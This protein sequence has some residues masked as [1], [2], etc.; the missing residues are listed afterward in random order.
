MPLLTACRAALATAL[1]LAGAL[2]LTSAPAQAAGLAD[3]YVALGDSFTAGPLIPGQYGSP[4]FC[5][6]SRQNYPNLVASALGADE[7][8]DASCSGATTE[9][10]TTSQSLALGTRN[11]PQFDSLTPDTTLVTVGIGGNDLGYGEILV[12]CAALSATNPIGDPCRRH[13]TDAD[14]GDQ[15]AERLDETAGKVADV[16]AG[17]RERSPNATVVVVGYLQVLPERTGCWPTVPVARQD[18]PY[19]D[20]TQTRLNEV[21]AK[22]AADAGA[23]YVD[24]LERGHDMCAASGSKWVEGIFPTQPAAPVHP[25]AAGMAA[26]GDRVVAAL[27]A[28]TGQRQEI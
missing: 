17:I 28:G 19:I 1:G 15:L 18:V 22:A 12:K 25:N 5:L 11:A 24:V 27:G 20:R 9:H 14:G 23:V 7:F 13:Y 3:R 4:V 8:V 2:A 6:R 21:L 10:M 26:V 16:L